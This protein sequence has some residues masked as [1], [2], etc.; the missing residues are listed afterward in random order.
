MMNM[1]KVIIAN[2]NKK[3]SWG[4]NAIPKRMNFLSKIFNNIN[5]CPSIEMNGAVNNTVNKR[6]LK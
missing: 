6:R 5:G 4:Q 3:K 1:I 2:T